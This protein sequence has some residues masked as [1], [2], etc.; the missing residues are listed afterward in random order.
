MTDIKTAS[1]SSREQIK[2]ISNQSPTLDYVTSFSGVIRHR[3]DVVSGPVQIE[4]RYVP[5]KLV[6]DANSL[7]AYLEAVEFSPGDSLEQLAGTVL[8]DLNNEIVPRWLHVT[9]TVDATMDVVRHSVTFE[10]RQPNWD[11]PAL[12]ARLTAI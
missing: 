3:N 12:L 9:A 10:D 6:M 2:C 4:V 7:P 8:V 11:N 5:D 1:S